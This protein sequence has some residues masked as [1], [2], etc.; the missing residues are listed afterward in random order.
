MEIVSN[1]LFCLSV[2]LFTHVLSFF[3]LNPSIHHFCLFSPLVPLDLNSAL[4]P[5]AVCVLHVNLVLIL[6][7]WSQSPRLFLPSL[8]LPQ[9]TLYVY[10][11]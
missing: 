1:R 5:L 2:S 3:L 4:S 7:S 11:H 9:P 10:I 6:C 8:V